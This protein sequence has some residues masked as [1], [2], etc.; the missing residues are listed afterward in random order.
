MQTNSVFEERGASWF[1]HARGSGVFVD[2]TVLTS[3]ARAVGL[4]TS[5]PSAAC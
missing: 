5:R 4:A 2:C 1:F 3:P